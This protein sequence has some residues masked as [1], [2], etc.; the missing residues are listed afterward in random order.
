[1]HMVSFVD[2]AGDKRVEATVCLLEMGDTLHRGAALLNNVLRM[3]KEDHNPQVKA[4][5]G[6]CIRCVLALIYSHDDD[7]H[8]LDSTGSVQSIES[9]TD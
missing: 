7:D 3:T 2:C 8:E 4:L 6:A 5:A 9:T 1:M